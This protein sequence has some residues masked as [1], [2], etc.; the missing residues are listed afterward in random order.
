MWRVDWKAGAVWA[1]MTARKQSCI[2]CGQMLVAVP[3]GG[4]RAHLSQALPALPL[5]CCGESDR[6]RPK[7]SAMLLQSVQLSLA[8][9][10]HARGVWWWCPN[11][12]PPPPPGSIAYRE[13]SPPSPISTTNALLPPRGRVQQLQLCS[14]E[15]SCFQW[16]WEWVKGANMD[17]CTMMWSFVFPE[18]HKD[19]RWCM[20]AVWSY[21]ADSV[22]MY[23]RGQRVVSKTQSAKV[24]HRMARWL[25]CHRFCDKSMHEVSEEAQSSLEMF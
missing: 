16:D 4:R 1:E 22:V 15:T 20:G 5:L 17:V 10:Q 8:W 21:A 18:E 14:V 23:G 25:L 24:H 11:P 19:T 9:R 2:G 13:G 6:W 3:A 12:S 7:V